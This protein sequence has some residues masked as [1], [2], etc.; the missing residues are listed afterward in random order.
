MADEK[1][2]NK[3]PR[4]NK[5]LDSALSAVVIALVL[6][7]FGVLW[8]QS[9]SIDEKLKKLDDATRGTTDGL[10]DTTTVLATHLATLT[11]QDENLREQNKDLSKQIEA[12]HGEIVKLQDFIGNLSPSARDNRK[13]PAV[14]ALPKADLPGSG[15]GLIRKTAEE[16]D[17]I[18]QSIQQKK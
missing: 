4:W 10:K 8:Q 2:E 9:T 5:V 18:L 13:P 7:F 1:E 11:I 3:K 6:G 17:R 16:R 15:P 14:G 12:L